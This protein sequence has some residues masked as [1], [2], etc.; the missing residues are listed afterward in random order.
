VPSGRILSLDERIGGNPIVEATE[1]ERLWT[2]RGVASE[3][4]TSALSPMCWSVWCYAHEDACRSAF[5]GMGV[6]D[7]KDLAVPADPDQ[8]A[9]GC[10]YGRVAINVDYTRRLFGNLP[11][12][13]GDDFERDMLDGNHTG[14][15]AE[16][17][18][19]RRRPAFFVRFPAAVISVM[20][21]PRL[22]HNRAL[23]WWRN[24]ILDQRHTATPQQRLEDATARFRDSMAVHM[25][26]RLLAQVTQSLL[27]RVSPAAG[28]D[29]FQEVLLGGIGEVVETR[30]AADL[31]RLSRRLLTEADFLRRHGYHG[32]SEGNVYTYSWREAPERLGALAA[33]YGRQSG[34]ESPEERE[35][36]SVRRRRVAERKLLQTVPL[37]RRW[38][39]RWLLARISNLLRKV[40]LCRS[41]YVMCL[42]GCRAAVRD[43]G[44]LLVEHG[45]LSE[46]DD[47][48]MLT[49]DELRQALTGQVTAISELVR[50]RWAE[51]A[52]YEKGRLPATFHGQPTLVASPAD[53]SEGARTTAGDGAAPAVRGVGVFG[54]TVTGK[55]RVVRDL[56]D[57]I[58]VGP[59]EVLICRHTD[60]SW[61][62]LMSLFSALVIDTGGP[63]SHAAIVARELGVPCVIG[64][65]NA[66]LV[67][68]D[69]ARVLVDADA[70]V[71]R[72]TEA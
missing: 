26:V 10:F 66:S 59:G 27:A 62:P 9:L 33:A 65:G 64:A 70:G 49:G 16:R 14:T 51:R 63:A 69:G 24:E 20:Y 18:S 44:R 19:R 48:F 52:E 54:G 60:P 22:H 38:I 25:R 30:V 32:P 50:Q 8:R 47:A 23:R 34:T 6:L 41:T 35:Q 40:Q 42:D 5:A 67:I 4:H 31:W 21:L 15:K 45:V 37:R 39:T 56:D 29:G 28:A 55:A 2:T 1:A 68:P 61:T 3:L 7:R 58:E 46:V 57:A 13:S 53:A 71:V 17:R 72:L 11:G 43:A 12:V 36:R